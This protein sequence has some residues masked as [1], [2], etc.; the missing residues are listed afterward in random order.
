[1]T[2]SISRITAVKLLTTLY[3]GEL[4]D[5]ESKIA[6]LIPDKRDAE[7]CQKIVLGT[8]EKDEE[9][10]ERINSVSKTPVCK[11]RPMLASNIKAS[12]YQLLYLDSIPD[13]AAVNEAVAITK[14]LVSPSLAGFTNAVIKNACRAA[15]EYKVKSESARYCLP[16]WII[17]S[18]KRDYGVE[19]A[20]RLCEGFLQKTADIIRIN[21][22]KTNAAELK[23]HYGERIRILNENAAEFI[24][25]GDVSEDE[26]FQKGFFHFQNCSSQLC[27]KALSPKE[28]DVIL[29]SCASPGG[30]SFTLA[31]EV[32]DK[33]VIDSV[34]VSEK[35]AEKIKSGAQRLGITSINAVV[36]DSTVFQSGREYDKILCDVPCSGLGQLR[37]RPYFKLKNESD[38]SGLPELQ[39]KIASNC[40]KMLKKG[41]TLVYSTCTLREEENGAVVKRLLESG[42]LEIAKIDCEIENV[43]NKNNMLTVIP[44][45]SYEGFFVA[46]LIKK[47]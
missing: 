23:E 35:K 19:N 47:G 5:V 18:F 24:F 27:A 8:V 37:K 44:N 39:Y 13:F 28:N 12:L 3:K 4:I 21:N 22:L 20:M 14:K 34:D 26:L 2:I 42:E 45:G 31:E 40:V 46:K 32:N 1:M 29:D 9:L 41:G 36:A 6:A 11:M 25:D 33:A 15:S 30:K 38:L 7:L 16:D 10:C 17:S 43:I